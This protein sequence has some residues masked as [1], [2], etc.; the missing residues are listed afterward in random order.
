MMTIRKK[1]GFTLTEIIIVIFVF[2][3]L[4][5]GVNYLFTHV[6]TS[7][8]QRLFS[9][10]NTDQARL[11]AKNFTN[12]LRIAAT[13]HDG[14]YAINQAGN[15]QIIFYSNYGQAPGIIARIR[16]YHADGILYKGVVV[17]SGDPLTY[18]LSQEKT[19]IVQNDIVNDSQP[20]FYYYD[21]NYT[22]S[23]T[24]LVQ[25]VNVNLVKYVK[26]NL[27]I[28]KQNSQSTTTFKINAGVTIR[29]LKTNLGD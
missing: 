12:E 17:P 26:L 24:P 14:S 27:N 4:A 19:Q 11:V 9:L 13:G 25:P 10:D 15:T 23:S 6:F 5:I 3:I 22:G 29:N 1:T 7:S 18:N 28:L 2:S 20:I 16:Y 21:G 8:K